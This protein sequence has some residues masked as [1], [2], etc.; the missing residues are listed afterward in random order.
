[1]KKNPLLKENQKQNRTRRWIVGYLDLVSTGILLLF[2][3]G[4]PVY[5]VLVSWL[6]LHFLIFFAVYVMI[7]YAVSPFIRKI[8]FGEYFL[9]A[10]EKWERKRR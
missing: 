8:K 10:F 6:G 9:E 4:I 5:Y 2:F 3:I 1:M 7:V